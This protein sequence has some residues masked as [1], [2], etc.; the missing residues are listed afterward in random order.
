MRVF[1]VVAKPFLVSQD[2]GKTVVQCLKT[3]GRFGAHGAKV[4]EALK[5]SYML[6]ARKQEL[7]QMKIALRMY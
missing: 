6:G 7:E 2:A 5:Q 1:L 3:D 4:M